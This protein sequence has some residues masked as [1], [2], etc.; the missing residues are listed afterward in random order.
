MCD[1]CFSV[2]YVDMNPLLIFI[3][4]LN[5]EYVYAPKQIIVLDIIV[6]VHLDILTEMILKGN[7]MDS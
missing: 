7:E 4:D 1:N 6:K 2:V 5:L 3:L